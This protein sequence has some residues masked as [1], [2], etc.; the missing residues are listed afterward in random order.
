MGYI[1]TVLSSIFLFLQIRFSVQTDRQTTVFARRLSD[2]DILTFEG[3]EDCASFNAQCYPKSARN[4]CKSCR[5][6]PTFTTYDRAEKMCINT[7]GIA[8]L[9][10]RT[11]H[12][13]M[14]VLNDRS[15]VLNGSIQAYHC[16][17]R[18]K[19][20]HPEL[21]SSDGSL[22]TPSWSW[23]K[24]LDVDFSLKSSGSLQNS[25]KNWQLK[26]TKNAISKMLSKYAGGIVRLQI[27]CK[28]QDAIFFT[29]FC[30]LFKIAGTVPNSRDLTTVMHSSEK[31]PGTVT[32]AAI[33][34]DFSKSTE[35]PAISA[36]TDGPSNDG[37]FEARKRKSGKSFETIWIVYITVPVMILLLIVVVCFVHQKR[38]K[39]M[40][41]R[42]QSHTEIPKSEVKLHEY[43]IPII[44]LDNQS[45]KKSNEQDDHTYETCSERKYDSPST[46]EGNLYQDLH[47]NGR[48][49]E[50]SLY[51]PLIKS[52][53]YV[54]TLP[55]H[56]QRDTEAKPTNV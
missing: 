1:K 21:H 32:S 49:K 40:R 10:C 28:Q 9:H 6:S 50:V 27:G 15:V 5:C 45:R 35:S 30:I 25:R 20:E 8:N 22:T 33:K 2:G 34:I 37:T 44:K 11:L 16:K 24:M 13:N 39:N 53:Q 42:G 43:D 23:V 46:C 26:F 17:I 7:N 14:P 4:M 48:E 36:T 41:M 18:E 31:I 54:N 55:E 38:R 3:K 19:E 52:V 51:Q 47:R 29:D 56:Q 12:K